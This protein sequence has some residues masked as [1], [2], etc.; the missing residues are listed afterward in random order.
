M[1]ET[2]RQV[3]CVLHNSLRFTH[4]SFPLK[5]GHVWIQDT[6]HFSVTEDRVYRDF[7]RKPS[8]S[9]CWSSAF[10]H[11][12]SRS[13]RVT[14]SLSEHRDGSQAFH[15]SVEFVVWVKSASW[16]TPAQSL[17]YMLHKRCLRVKHTPDPGALRAGNPPPPTPHSSSHLL[18]ILI[19]GRKKNV[20][21]VHAFLFYY[22]CH[23]VH[24]QLLTNNAIISPF[25]FHTMFVKR[26][27]S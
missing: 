17:T 24:I 3:S 15:P 2:S 1:N 20:V 23:G 14:Q 5:Y 27:G 10:R 22:S 7:W 12:R 16:P 21:C 9:S 25:H 18:H 11:A 4:C 6:Q 26:K 8:C 13:T 19:S